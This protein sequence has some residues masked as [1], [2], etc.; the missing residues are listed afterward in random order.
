VV[1]SVDQYEYVE[2]QFLV[3]IYYTKFVQRKGK[4]VGQGCIE[5]DLGDVHCVSWHRQHLWL[6]RSSRLHRHEQDHHYQQDFH[7]ELTIF[8]V[9]KKKID[10]KKKKKKN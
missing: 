8:I 1:E 6:K 3:W 7:Q 10:L 9:K 4:R 5:K 2:Q